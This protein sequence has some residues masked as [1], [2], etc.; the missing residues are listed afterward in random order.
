MAP[1]E[2]LGDLLRNANPEGNLLAHQA[3]GKL[4]SRLFGRGRERVQLGRYVVEDRIGAGGSGVVYR[5]FDP[6]YDRKVAL[7]LLHAGQGS[8]YEAARA[9]LLREA[10]SLAKLSHPNVVRIFDVG[11]YDPRVFDP[12]PQ[13]RF[14]H[15]ASP[16]EPEPDPGV[17]L[18]MELLDGSDLCEWLAEQRRDW[19]AIRAAFLAAGRGLA[20]A[21]ALGLIHRDFKPTNVSVDAKGE[22]R[23]LDFGLAR[24]LTKGIPDPSMKMTEGAKERL[25]QLARPFDA[26]LT[27][28]GTL[29]GTPAYMAPEQ[30]DRKPA[31]AQS[32]QYAFCLALYEA[33]Y[34]HRPFL[35][36]T[37][38]ELCALKQAGD[39]LPPP[40]QGP[41]PRHYFAALRRGMAPRPEDRFA[42]M[43]ALLEALVA[44]APWLR[45]P[46]SWPRLAGGVLALG[47]LGV[48]TWA[49]LA[50][51]PC[52]ARGWAEHWGADQR[53]ALRTSASA[54]PYATRA[55][56]R[57]S[58]QLDALV[59]RGDSVGA[60]SCRAEPPEPQWV[61]C[62]A[63]QR[64]RFGSLVQTVLAAEGSTLLHAA[65][66]LPRWPSP[67]QC[68]DQ[69]SSSE[70]AFGEAIADA[71]LRELQ[72]RAGEALELAT[73]AHELAKHQ[74]DTTRVA[75][76]A[77]LEGHLALTLGRLD[78]AESALTRALWSRSSPELRE[79][80][81]E[82]TIDLLELARS[83]AV[84]PV[85]T[86]LWIRM[87]R[88][89]AASLDTAVAL[90]Q[91]LYLGL[92]RLALAREEPERA[93]RDLD[94]GLVLPTEYAD[95]AWR[96]ELQRARAEV[97]ERQGQATDAERLRRQAQTEAERALGAG[98]PRLGAAEP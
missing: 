15:R 40:V 45:R 80:L 92:G 84:P 89:Q 46:R 98:H 90:R 88:E 54:E 63:G 75:R 28:P 81:A 74:G 19:Q 52:E 48:T 59:E 23:V 11:T 69:H 37:E 26:T 20:A 22:V 49:M 68:R 32:D 33:W 51:S 25:D 62:L 53:E 27:A 96:L 42:S 76:A 12:S 57:V 5:A 50:R 35:A 44:P 1:S 2:S 86:P 94:Q 6:K 39:L 34:G 91:R 85:D 30:H 95:P 10:Q 13:A 43:D 93:R 29:L 36:E 82:V 97:M 71:R 65:D 77:G 66:A 73:K 60:A 16:G 61:D 58:E 8:G 7:K 72:G 87:A 17:Y 47:G 21:H 41:I 3:L 79:L 24:P 4:Q 67:E 14:G 56:E 55:A 18:A 83:S 31:T 9:R 70:L 64:E 78:H 38:A